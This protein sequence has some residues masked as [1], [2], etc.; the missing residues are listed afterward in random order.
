MKD[1]NKEFIY[2][3]IDSRIIR[4]LRIYVLVLLILLVVILF[5]LIQGNF[6][7]NIILLGIL[8]GLGVGIISSRTYRLSWDSETDNV[9]SRMDWIGA[10]ILILYLIFIFTRVDLLE[11]WIHGNPL[12]AIVISITAGTM[13][14]RLV[15]TRHEV[16]KILKSRLRELELIK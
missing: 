5:E 2:Q 6:T 9:I 12:F 16:A 4:R 7:I 3:H 1:K 10:V 11:R 13:L 14:G 8:I 15:T